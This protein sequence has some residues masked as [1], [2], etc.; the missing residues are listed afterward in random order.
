VEKEIKKIKAKAFG[1]D[2]HWLPH[3]Q[4]SLELAKI[5]KKYHPES[6]VIFG[7]LSSTYFHQELVQYP[8]VDFVLRG[9][10][11][12]EPLYLL[13]QALKNGEELS[14]VPNLTYNNNGEV[15]V[16]LLSFVPKN[17][18]YS[19]IDYKHLVKQVIKYRDF[20]GFVPFLDWVRYPITAIFSCRGCTQ[21]CTT[22]GGSAFTYNHFSQRPFPAF[23]SPELVA[24][25]VFSIE[26]LLA[27][28]I[29]ILGDIMQAGEEYA[30]KL[31]DCLKEKK[32]RNQIVL[33]FFDVPP[34]RI[35]EKIA[36]SLPHFN[37][38]ISLE[39]HDP[40]V[41][42][43]FGRPED[44]QRLEEMIET[45]LK[46]GCQKFDLFFMTGLPKQTFQSVMDTVKYC[47][48]LLQ[49]FGSYQRLFPYISPLAP[50]VDPGSM[51]FENP[52]KFGYTLF[53]KTLEE[54]RQALLNPSW[55][56]MLNYQTQWMT[57]DQIVESTYKAALELN[58]LKY[59][60][61]LLEEKKFKEIERKIKLAQEALEKID[62][63]MEI[64]EQNEREKKL[65]ELKKE[66]E[67]LNSSTVAHKKELEWKVH[68]FR[69]NLSNLLVSFPLFLISLFNRK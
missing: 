9:D 26:K 28:P 1:I 51:V 2:L 44:N 68:F 66:L 60:Y 36:Q 29:F 13:L 49:K 53:C 15:K 30:V 46:L 39:S 48:Y 41:R 24:S 27:G 10:S 34:K 52:Q 35:L 55:K 50:F 64:K 20:W 58:R 62:K 18:D 14:S 43:I 32:C 23:R 45:S 57:K 38:Q 11:T 54:H 8:Q 59:K 6:K 25:D 3:A 37:F 7:G 22:C 17:L 40:E 65:K 42:K 16:N 5:V 69:F 31:L 12:E 47:E 67:N 61:G 56:H 19:S 33:E 21:D 4:G 63:I